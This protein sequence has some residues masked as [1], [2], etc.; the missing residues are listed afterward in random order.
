MKNLLLAGIAATSILLSGCS[1]TQ[2]EYDATPLKLNKNDSFA[3][4][5]LK[6]G[7]ERVP[8]NIKDQELPEDAYQDVLSYGTSTSLGLFAGGGLGALKGLGFAALM[9][10]GG[11][12]NKDKIHFVAWIPVT[13]FDI[14]NAMDARNYISKHYMEPAL[15]A[16]IESDENK[17][18]AVPSVY[19]DF[20]KGNLQI[21]GSAC[22]DF[23]LGKE[24]L[25]CK[26]LGGQ[27]LWT[28]RYANESVGTPFEPSVKAEKYIVARFSDTL[29]R[30]AVLLKYLQTDMM[31]AFVP[32]FG[33]R[34]NNINKIVSDTAFRNTPYVMGKNNT[35]HFFI[36]KET[37]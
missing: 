15:K 23:Y 3:M 11:D 33:H 4:Q 35:R 7:F 26:V 28:I 12:P 29:Y 24:A 22:F 13:D 19:K 37:K 16:Y 17:K 20:S 1:T 6:S 36:K 25:N 31:Y 2:K 8:F 34:T 9:N 30:S 27:G 21:E 18:S 14:T 5:V 10:A 32:A